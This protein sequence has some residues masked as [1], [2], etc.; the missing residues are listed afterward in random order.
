MTEAAGLPASVLI[1]NRGEIASRIIRTCRKLGVRTVAVYSDADRTAPHVS[2]ADDAV[3][4]GRSPASE[5]YLNI[6]SIV[7]A[8][9]SSGAEAVHP[10]YGFLSE[11]AD[12]AQ[13]VVDAGLTWIGPPAA[14]IDAL[15]DKVSARRLAAEAGVPV[16]EGVEEDEGDAALAA[17]IVSMGLPVMIKAAAGG[18]GRGMR[19]IRSEEDA[20]DGIEA[21]VAGARREAQAAFGDG[22]L[23]VERAL[24]E[25]RH[26]EVQVIFD[27]HGHGV[28]LGERDCSVQRRR[29]KVIEEAPSP[30]VDEAL[31]ARFGEAALQV[32]RAAGYVGAGTVEFMLMPGGEFM[33]LEVNARIQVEHPVTE[34]LTGL[35]LVELQL[36]VAG[37]EPLP[38]AQDDVTFAGH[39]IETRIYAEDPSRGYVPSTGRLR[40]FE[41]FDDRA[42]HDFGPAPGD[43]VTAHYDPM[44]AKTIVH[45]EDRAAALAR[46]SEALNA[47]AIDGVTTNLAQL[48]AVLASDDFGAGAVDIGWLDRVELARSSV[49]TE[50]VSAAALAEVSDGAWRS[51]GELVRKYL[52]HG[53]AHEV[54]LRRTADGWLA[55]VDGGEAMLVPTGRA[56]SAEVSANGVVVSNGPR[57]W[58]FLRERRTRT[59]AGRSRASGA[60]VVR[61]PMPGTMIEVLVAVGDEVAAGQTLAIMEAMKIEHLLTAPNGG[62]VSA[63]HTS[64]GSSVDE[65][66]I[67]I[68][69][70]AP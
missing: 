14:V 3:R 9:R 57:R 47:W 37:G 22:R 30:A 27:A 34:M 44:L 21:A 54:R 2:A 29:Q 67:L 8:A 51:S 64:A 12:F 45:A 62:V 48:S 26:V 38:I 11:R 58:V 39:A 6:A 23:L 16:A 60:N 53:Q 33:F 25:G 10:G 28:H 68:E 46:S 24:S 19:L 35:D 5:S 43:V 42:R 59:G 20:L 55:S 70:G 1:A 7:D 66:A 17:E 13:A 41:P 4:I 36:R 50:A 40:W 63:I 18:G 32:C 31:R 65:D 61:A 15:G 49:P 52:L 69:L 56:W